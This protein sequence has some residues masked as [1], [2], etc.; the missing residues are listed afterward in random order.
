[1]GTAEILLDDSVL[2]AERAREAGVDVSLAVEDD[3]IHVWHYFAQVIPE[4]EQSVRDVGAF[5][6]THIV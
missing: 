1:V 5:I 2:L 3:M 4:G 6:R